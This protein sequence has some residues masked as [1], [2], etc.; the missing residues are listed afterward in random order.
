MNS[1]P[2]KAAAG[3]ASAEDADQFHQPTARECALLILRLI[4]A[5][6]D[7]SGRTVTRARLTEATLRHLWVRSRVTD[8]LLGA[9]QEILLH[10]GWALFW[11]GTSYAIIKL[12]VVSGWGRIASKPRLE[13]EL[14]QVKR[15][16]YDRFGELEKVLLGGGDTAERDD[17]SNESNESGSDR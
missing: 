1:R 15:G 16:K 4:Q 6:E 10:G 5:K 13:L 14:Q 17:E 9:V 12:N 11:A 8:D 3:A 2:V 7:E